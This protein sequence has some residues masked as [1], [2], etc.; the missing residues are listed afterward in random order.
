MGGRGHRV[1]GRSQWLGPFPSPHRP[2][3]RPACCYGQGRGMGQGRPHFPESQG[4]VPWCLT[5]GR[6][7][8]L[9]RSRKEVRLAFRPH[10]L[11]VG[12]SLGGGGGRGGAGTG[13]WAMRCCALVNSALSVPPPGAAAP[14]CY[15]VIRS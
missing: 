15:L 3:R 5:E 4:S 7:D 8:A 9:S 11:A 1:P 10:C 14:T 13:A 2:A 12:R 6:A